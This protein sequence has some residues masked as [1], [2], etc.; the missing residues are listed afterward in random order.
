MDGNI[1]KLLIKMKENNASDLHIA[2]NAPM[3]YRI[4]SDLVVACDRVL[5]PDDVREI[6]Y[7]LMSDEQVVRLER[8]KELD[9]S[10][11]IKDVARYRV[12]VFYQRSW[13]G[14]AIRMIPVRIRSIEECGLPGDTIIGFCRAHQGLVLVTGA[15]GSGK[16]TTLAAMVNEINRT[17]KCHIV[18]VEDP[19]EFIHQNNLAVVDQR[20]VGL[21]TRSFSDALMRVLRQDPDVIL[22]GELRDFETIQQALI[23]ADTGHLVLATLHTADSVQTINRIVDVFPSHQQRQIRAQLSFDLLGIISQQLVDKADGSGRVLAAEMLVATPSVRTMIR[24]EKTHQIYSTIQTSQKSGM[25]TMNQS[26]SDLYL[27]RVITY[28]SAMSRS[29]DPAELEKLIEH[30]A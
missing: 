1:R 12:N 27:S 14:C 8:D 28:E 9:F 3:H 22:I 17:R 11:E 18:T 5:T 24:D 21:D 4:N 25:R 7:S 15:T 2:A 6:T 30:S 16:S 23:I 19:L 29:L 10:F 20:E 26:L 13:V